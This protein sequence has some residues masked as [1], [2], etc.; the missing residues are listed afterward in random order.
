MKHGR[1]YF[2]D[3]KNDVHSF[4]PKAQHERNNAEKDRHSS[5]VLFLAKALNGIHPS[6]RGVKI[7]R[8]R[9]LPITVPQSNQ[10]LGKRVSQPT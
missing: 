10:R 3:F 8:Q 1:Y 5:F 9:R 7:V 4:F 6:L 2:K